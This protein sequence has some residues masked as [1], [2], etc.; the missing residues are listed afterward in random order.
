MIFIEDASAEKAIMD[1]HVD[2]A[3]YQVGRSDGGQIKRRATELVT[4]CAAERNIS[5][6][7]T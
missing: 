3:D 6:G 5:L 1:F 2:L 7:S 4:A